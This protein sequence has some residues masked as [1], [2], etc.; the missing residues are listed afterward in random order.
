M[1]KLDIF[2]GPSQIGLYLGGISKHS[3]AFFLKVKIQNWNIF[4]GC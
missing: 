3:M 1:M 4:G 2:R